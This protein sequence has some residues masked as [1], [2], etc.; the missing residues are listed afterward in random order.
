MLSPT[1]EDGGSFQSF[2]PNLKGVFAGSGTDGLSDPRMV[3]T[4]LDLLPLSSKKKLTAALAAK[5]SNSNNDNNTTNANENEN[6]NNDVN[7]LY[8]GTA[9]YDI[10]KFKLKQTK[11]FV[12]RGCKVQSL[13]ISFDNDN[14]N[15]DSE[16]DK[17]NN[18]KALIENADIIV[19]GGGNT[20]FAVDRWYKKGVIPILEIAMERGCILTG[21]SAGA[22]C[23]FHS[24]HSDSAD[25]DTYVTAMLQKYSD[26][27]DDT[28][29]SC[30]T[31]YDTTSNS[32]K[33][34]KDWN[35]IRVPGLNFIPN[36]IC[37]PHHDKVQT[38]IVDGDNY[39]VFSL[40]DKVGSIPPNNNTWNDDEEKKQD[41]GGGDFA[42]SDQ[43]IATGTPGIW[44]KRIVR[45]TDTKNDYNN[46][47]NKNFT[48]DAQI[49]P[50][51]GKL[52][53]IIHTSSS[54][55]STIDDDTIDIDDTDIDNK[56]ELERCRKE[57]PSS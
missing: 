36:V 11:C 16:D 53:A 7:V 35:Y 51:E 32:T 50:L 37:C 38:L 23:W 8:I 17:A 39:R 26:E 57:N 10:P 1:Q 30:S 45:T 27:N 6:D 54:S 19:V 3:D 52:K 33:T 40:Q 22:I 28:V 13:D 43:G 25:P 29:V 24:G 34:K 9:T 21:G 31:S 55:S 2:H 14:D 41:G 42:V 46:N 47:S 18:N 4:I 49:L 48:I 12:E 15:N 20:L 44:I 56:N 5:L